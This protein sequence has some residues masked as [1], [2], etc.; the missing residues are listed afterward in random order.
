MQNYVIK[1]RHKDSGGMRMRGTP[2]GNPG[3]EISVLDTILAGMYNQGR[4]GTNVS[5][6]KVVRTHIINNT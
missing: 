4:Q 3:A 2:E 1:R 6:C 5:R